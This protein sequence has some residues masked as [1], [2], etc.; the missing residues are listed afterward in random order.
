MNEGAARTELL[1]AA[2]LWKVE[3]LAAGRRARLAAAVEALA[4]HKTPDLWRQLR[5]AA[6]TAL[7]TP[8][9]RI[10]AAREGIGEVI[11][12]LGHKPGGPPAAPGPMPVND[13]RDRADL[14]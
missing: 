2:Y 14:R 6:R 1:L 4:G 3:P 8:P 9:E 7:E 12:A 5:D 11:A 10:E 13:W